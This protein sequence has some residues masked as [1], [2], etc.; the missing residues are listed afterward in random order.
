MKFLQSQQHTN[1]SI[2]GKP[3]NYESG[4]TILELTVV[5]TI[6]A[7]IA[8]T[9]LSIGATRVMSS[10]IEDTERKM[11]LIQEALDAYVAQFNH[12]PCP[13]DGSLKLTDANFGEEQL[14][15]GSPPGDWCAGVHVSASPHLHIGVLPINELGLEPAV[16]IDGWGRRFTYA[17][18]ERMA[19]SDTETAAAGDGFE[20]TDIDDTTAFPDPLGAGDKGFTILNAGGGTVT[21]RAIVVIISHGANGHGAWPARGGSVLNKS[22]A[23]TDEQEN[24]DNINAVPNTLD[25]VF[26][27]KFST[28]TFDDIVRYNMRWQ[29]GN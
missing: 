22:S 15:S 28:D 17:V 25:G 11:D 21:D 29:L 13:A 26:V 6:I 10:K 14:T 2:N 8:G 19:Y 12:L 9:A 7:L 20:N 3:T 16:S 1:G 27:Q 5:L 18:D 23:D 24:A 4:F